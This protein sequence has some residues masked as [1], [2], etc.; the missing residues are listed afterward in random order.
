[1]GGVL[2]GNDGSQV[3]MEFRILLR[4]QQTKSKTKKPTKKNHQENSAK[5]HK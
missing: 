4:M 3:F 1:V 5:R 2:I